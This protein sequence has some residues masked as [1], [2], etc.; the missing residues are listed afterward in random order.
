MTSLFELV[1]HI[2]NTA[3]FSTADPLIDTM[4]NTLN[5]YIYIYITTK[6][7]ISR[8]W[9]NTYTNISILLFNEF[10]VQSY[11][12]Y[13]TMRSNKKV[14]ILLQIPDNIY[15]PWLNARTLTRRADYISY[16]YWLCTVPSFATQWLIILVYLKSVGQNTFNITQPDQ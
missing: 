15:C 13:I 14:L 2:V 4:F 11:W 8:L 16:V 6:F 9:I 3:L 5:I 7:P 1:C 10:T 12:C